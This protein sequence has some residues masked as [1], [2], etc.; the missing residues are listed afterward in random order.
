MRRADSDIDGVLYS[1]RYEAIPLEDFFDWS[2]LFD[3]TSHH[4]LLPNLEGMYYQEADPNVGKN[5]FRVLFSPSVRSFRVL[6]STTEF[7]FDALT[8]LVT[9]SPTITDLTLSPIDSSLPVGYQQ[10]TLVQHICAFQNLRVLDLNS[11]AYHPQMLSMLGMLPRLR[12]LVIDIGSEVETAIP[13]QSNDS[14]PSL[15]ELYLRHVPPSRKMFGIWPLKPLLKNLR[16]VSW[17]IYAMSTSDSGLDKYWA[18]PHL[19]LISKNAP[20]LST[21]SVT[22]ES[23]AYQL[24]PA[25]LSTK[26]Q[27]AMRHLPLKIL[28]LDN[29]YFGGTGCALLSSA[30]LGIEVLRCGM[31][32][33]E[34]VDLALFAQNLPYLKELELDVDMSGSMIP[35]DI[36]PSP[37]HTTFHRLARNVP[38]LY[39]RSPEQTVKLARYLYALWP[40]V[41]CVFARVTQNDGLPVP[42][43]ISFYDEAGAHEQLEQLNACIAQVR[44]GA[45]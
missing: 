19:L 31:Q 5:W 30:W 36:V 18:N 27:R 32:Q 37:R 29:I 21:L 1:A 7:L 15:R 13:E 2:P 43:G 34:L 11:L 3:Y 25:L 28:S 4:T 40:D 42:R 39:G 14:F 33:C 6:N 8:L 10:D 41:L 17:S 45:V 24:R 20:H 22:T 44:A 26:V 38:M 12:R 16:H 23:W 35:D 9:T